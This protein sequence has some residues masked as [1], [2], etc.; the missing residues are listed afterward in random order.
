MRVWK[1]NLSSSPLRAS[2]PSCFLTGLL[3][4]V[5]VAEEEGGVVGSGVGVDCVAVGVAA[6]KVGV[7]VFKVGAVG[8]NVAGESTDC[9]EAGPAIDVLLLRSLS[10]CSET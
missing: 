7:A 10:L 4:L 1:M 2:S 3:D 5:G 9:V 6:S 8:V